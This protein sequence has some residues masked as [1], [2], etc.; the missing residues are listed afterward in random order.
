MR[1][2]E[3]LEKSGVKYEVTKHAVAFSA[4]TMAAVMHESGKYV[5]KPVLVK[6]DDKYF[7]CV[8]PASFKIDFQTLKR[9]LGA[10]SVELATEEDIGRLFPDCELGAEPPFGNLYDV[11][12]IMDKSL[13]KDDHIMFQAGSHEK[14]IRMSM[15]DFRKLVNPCMMD[16]SYR[17]V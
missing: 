15:A 12:T 17:A 1:I 3:F 9:Q 16:F 2:T 10:K 13:E 11:P 14:A 6:A 7:L 4:Q 5:A 8:L